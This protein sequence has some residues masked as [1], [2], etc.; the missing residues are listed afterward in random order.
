MLLVQTDAGGVGLTLTRADKAVV[1]ELPWTAVGMWQAVKRVHRI[2]QTREVRADVLRASGCWLE[3]S[4]ASAVS[5]K[6]AASERL[7]TLLESRP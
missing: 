3:Q 1:A 6:H 2:T 4:L 5:R 7:L